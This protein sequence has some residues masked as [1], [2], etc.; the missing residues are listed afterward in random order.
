M[1]QY[2]FLV[3]A[4]ETE[5]LKVLTVWSTA[6]DED[7]HV[8]PR[9]GDNR[10]RNL[11]EHMVHQCSSEN[12]WFEGMFGIKV[13][14]RPLP[15]AEKR[16][17]FVQH[18]A[19]CAQ[20][21]LAA[22]REKPDAWWQ[23]QVAFFEVP[24]SRAWIMVRRIAHTAHHRGQQTTLLR[25]QG[26]GLYSTYGPTADTGGLLQDK[27]PVLYPYP[28]LATLLREEARDRKK[29]PLPPPPNRPVT[30]RPQTG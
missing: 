3:D 25:R 28:D 22:L 14:S 6:A 21:R 4:Y 2:D 30:E 9:P 10:G 26:R 20:Q 1:S 16:L 24:R 23:E 18:Y 12:A 5:I 7:L 11:L 19:A 17:D 29:Q 13:T 15:A 27:A 8:R